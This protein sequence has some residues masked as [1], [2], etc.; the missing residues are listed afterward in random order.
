MADAQTALLKVMELREQGIGEIAKNIQKAEQRSTS[1][2]GVYDITVGT[3]RLYGSDVVYK[4][5]VTTEIA[6][7]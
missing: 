3:S 5:Y 6:R 4:R 1:K 7:R 2:D